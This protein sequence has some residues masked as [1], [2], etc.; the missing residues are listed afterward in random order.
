MHSVK[1]TNTEVLQNDYG[2]GNNIE[3]RKIL[4]AV[5]KTPGDIGWVNSFH[6]Q[7]LHYT[8]ADKDGVRILGT[9]RVDLGNGRDQIVEFMDG[10]NWIS[11]QWHPEFDWM[12]N[13]Y[14]RAVLSRFKRMLETA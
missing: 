9:A 2:L 11:C 1:F 13:S 4:E 10:E 3:E 12:E 14:S 5:R 7:A 8:A 6:H